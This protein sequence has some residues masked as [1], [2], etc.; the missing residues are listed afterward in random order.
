M[1]SRIIAALTTAACVATVGLTSSS[2][3]Q[4]IV[5]GYQVTDDRFGFMASIQYA[6]EDGTSGHFCGGSVIDKRWILTAAHC[7]VLTE[8]KPQDIQ[9]AVGR[10]NI[11]EDLAQGQTLTVDRIEVHPDYESTNT[12]DAALI[13]VTEDITTAPAIPLV[14]PGEDSLEQEGAALTVAGWGTE[15]FGAPV[16]PA[17]L[18]AVDVRAVAD[19]NCTTNGVM[20]FQPDSEICASELL[21]DSCQGDSGGPLFGELADG[22]RVQVGIVSYG[23]GCATPG[24]PGVYAEVN[25]ASIHGF[26]TGVVGG[27]TAPTS[28][29]EGKGGKGGGPKK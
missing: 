27:T 22:R 16:V 4:A 28:P 13:H 29:S 21:G 9:V 8:A 15:F 14:A 5:G 12:F 10:D 3:A 7:I 17:Q 11:D 20:G 6:G 25:N 2:P 18:K 1:R 24:F 23:L 19:E 26:I